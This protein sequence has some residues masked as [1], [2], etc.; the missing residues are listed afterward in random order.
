MAR[1]TRERMEQTRQ[2]LVA[3]ARALFAEK[4]YA[5]TATPDIVAAAGV[6]RGA[7]Y[8]HFEDKKA[9]FQ[10]VIEAEAEAVAAAIEAK[11]AQTA[12]ARE[13]LLLGAQAY[14]DAMGEPGRTRLMLLEAPAVLGIGAVAKID[15]EK[16]EARLK[17]GLKAYLEEAGGSLKGLDALTALLSS[18]FDRAALE[19]HAG[20]RRIEYEIAIRT[21][22]DG[23]PTTRP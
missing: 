16:S 5:D 19:I 21:L 3:A 18:A 8:H 22:V 14:F 23:L 12:T 2:A 7:L 13:A 6:T 4:G 17:E 10:A 9:L 1:N 11:S 20:G 15:S